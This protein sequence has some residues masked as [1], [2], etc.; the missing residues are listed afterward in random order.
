MPPARVRL[1]LA[2][3]H[4]ESLNELANLLAG[5][6][7]ITGIA[8]DGTQL[9]DLAES[10]RPDVVVTDLQMPELNGI[11]AARALLARRL[12]T[13]VVITTVYGDPQ[14]ARTALEA[15]VHGYVLKVNAS[16]DLIPAINLALCGKTFV[17]AEIWP[18][19]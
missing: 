13:A 5:E 9:V 14:L 17:S 3:D 2:D 8:R 7:E 1:I 6:F 19:Y 10:L 18:D 16:E 4:E 15:G 11:E 12:C